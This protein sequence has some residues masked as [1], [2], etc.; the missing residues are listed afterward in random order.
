MKKYFFLFTLI[1]V[2]SSCKVLFTEQFRKQA[3]ATGIDILKIQFYNSDKIILKRILSSNEVSVTSGK[4]KVEN[5]KNIEIIKIKKNT[6]GKCELI[7][8]NKLYI[9]FEEGENKSFVFYGNSSTYALKPDECSIVKKNTLRISLENKILPIDM[10]EK[11]INECTV[12]YDKKKY[13]VELSSMP[14]LMFKKIWL[15]KKQIN[16]RTVKGV[17]VE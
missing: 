11:D 4:V 5:G 6:L 14:N 7:D 17:K 8:K 12:M 3:E 16:K 9:S 13:S 15:N 1:S 10:V 2:F